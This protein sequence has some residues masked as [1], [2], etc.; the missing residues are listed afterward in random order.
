[1]GEGGREGGGIWIWIWRPILRLTGSMGWSMMA[2]PTTLHIGKPCHVMH[3]QDP[4]QTGCALCTLRI[5]S[6]Y[7]LAH[8]P[9]PLPSF[10]RGYGG[11][12]P[13][14]FPLQL[15]QLQLPCCSDCGCRPTIDVLQQH[16]SRFQ[17]AGVAATLPLQHVDCNS[18]QPASP[19]YQC[20]AK[21][22]LPVLPQCAHRAKFC[23]SANTQILV[24]AH[25]HKFVVL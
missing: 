7:P 3:S 17:A 9:S 13:V 22:A 5:R 19:C 18:L 15:P 25:F 2:S 21:S 11:A 1:M 24:L 4:R 20:R 16:F 12:A 6:R 8:C 14:A 23:M 10:L